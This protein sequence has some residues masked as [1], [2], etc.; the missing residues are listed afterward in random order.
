MSILGYIVASY[1]TAGFFFAIAFAIKG[2]KIL[3]EGA[4]KSGAT[5]RIMILPGALLLW[6]YLLK[7]WLGSA[8]D[9]DGASHD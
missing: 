2:C 8:V 9:V 4:I 7:R 6:P 5:F 1:L 3:D